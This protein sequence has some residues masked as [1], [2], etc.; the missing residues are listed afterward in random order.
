MGSPA[1]RFAGDRATYPGMQTAEILV[2]R[3]FLEA[4]G[5][6]YDRFDYNV[7]LGPGVIPPDSLVEPYRSA[8]I[9][10]SKLRVD[11]VGWRGGLP[12]LFEVER[13]AKPRAIGQLLAYRAA[14]EAAGGSVASP[15]VALVC[16]DYNPHIMP[17]LTEHGIDLYQFPVDF[18]AL[19]PRRI[20]P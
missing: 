2:W 7:R 5:A 9:E 1:Q 20:R 16:A 14:W 19:A 13:Y 11:A 4:Q 12:T 15:G 17:A 18:T 6:S 3:R 10:A 8:S